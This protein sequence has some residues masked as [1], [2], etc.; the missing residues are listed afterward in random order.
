MGAISKDGMDFLCELGRR[1]TQCTDDHHES[2][3]LFQGLSIG[4]VVRTLVFGWQ[5]F[6]GP[7]LICGC[8]VWPL[9]GQSVRYG[10]ANQVNSAFR[11]YGVGKWVVIHVLHGLRGWRSSDQGCFWLFC[12]RSKYVGAGLDYIAYKLYA[13]SVCDTGDRQNWKGGKGEGEREVVSRLSGIW[14]LFLL[15]IVCLKFLFFFSYY[16][17]AK[18]RP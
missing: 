4:S 15:A 9:C 6:P 8:H 10:S 7:C 17:I 14:T 11:Q 18:W 12:C 13:R 3:F 16:F 5:I 1:I 2:A